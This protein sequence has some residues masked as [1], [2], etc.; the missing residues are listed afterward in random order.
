MNSKSSVVKKQEIGTVEKLNKQS[1]VVSVVQGPAKVI[2]KN[3]FKII[4]YVDDGDIVPLT[5][6][7]NFWKV[8]QSRVRIVL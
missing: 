6:T 8:R 4:G 7:G 3:M 2:Q 5:L 1:K